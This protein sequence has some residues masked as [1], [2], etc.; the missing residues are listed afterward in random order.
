MRLPTL[1]VLAGLAE[2]VSAKPAL[3][4]DRTIPQVAF[5]AE[6]IVRAAG[7]AMPEFD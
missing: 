5:A 2:V 6:E 1:V 7:A 3:F 4:Y